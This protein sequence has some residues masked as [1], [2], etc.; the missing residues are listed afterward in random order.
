MRV[1]A[2][3]RN[4]IYSVRIGNNIAV[5]TGTDKT[6]TARQHRYLLLKCYTWIG[7]P[8]YKRVTGDCRE[9]SK[10]LSITKASANFYQDKWLIKHALNFFQYASRVFN[11]G[12][13]INMPLKAQIPGIISSKHIRHHGFAGCFI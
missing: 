13:Y 10:V 5:Q 4:I 2:N 9:L 8:A 11:R 6:R 12:A 3:V 7:D 1:L